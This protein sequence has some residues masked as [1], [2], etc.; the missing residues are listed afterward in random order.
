MN[1][2]P[3]GSQWDLLPMRHDRNADLTFLK[4]GIGCFF[5]WV[6]GGGL[7]C[8][9]MKPY[10]I[11]PVK[12]PVQPMASPRLPWLQSLVRPHV[13]R[14]DPCLQ[15]ICS[16]DYSCWRTSAFVPLE[17]SEVPSHHNHQHLH[18]LAWNTNTDLGPSGQLLFN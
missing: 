4:D 17:L 10:Y 2:Q 1:L 9:A 13:F 18:S 12:K 7:S 14:T 11:S 5:P 3:H 16:V 15:C 8:S 6:L